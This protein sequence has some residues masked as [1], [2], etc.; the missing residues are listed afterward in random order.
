MLIAMVAVLAAAAPAASREQPLFPPDRS[1][2]IAEQIRTECG[3]ATAQELKALADRPR[4]A[5]PRCFVRITAKESNALLPRVIE[6]GVVAKSA[7][8]AE[9]TLLV[10]TLQL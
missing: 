3:H 9:E 8:V 5:A 10:L 7:T 6:P 4:E 1:A 2:S